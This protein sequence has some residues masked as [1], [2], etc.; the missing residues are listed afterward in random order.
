MLVSPVCWRDYPKKSQVALDA[1]FEMIRI[2]HFG[3]SQQK[4]AKVAFGSNSEVRMLNR[5]VG[6]AH[7]NR[8]RQPSLGRS[9]KCQARTSAAA[10]ACPF[11][12]TALLQPTQ[13]TKDASHDPS[14]GSPA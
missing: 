4:V 13:P 12:L 8:H 7:Y 5:K 11:V 6:F 9:E 3:A 2:L 14:S 1:T 10:P